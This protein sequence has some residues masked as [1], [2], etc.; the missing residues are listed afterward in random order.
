MAKEKPEW[1]VRLDQCDTIIDLLESLPGRAE[2]FATSASETV[3][4][5]EEWIEK[6]HDVTPRQCDALDNIKAGAERWQ[7]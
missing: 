6:N 3:H 1:R 5:I 4:D 7:E 2:D